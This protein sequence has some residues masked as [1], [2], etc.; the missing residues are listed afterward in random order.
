MKPFAETE[1]YP[2]FILIFI[3]EFL[4]LKVLIEVVF[5]G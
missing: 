3:D 2:I 4:R 1:N 5:S